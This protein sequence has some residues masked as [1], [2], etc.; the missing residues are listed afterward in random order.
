MATL[1]SKGSRP[2]P[3]Q[4][5][6]STP[7][8]DNTPAPRPATVPKATVAK[9]QAKSKTKQRRKRYQVYVPPDH[10]LSK[11]LEADTRKPGDVVVR[12]LAN[13]TPIIE[14]GRIPRHEPCGPRSKMNR[15]NIFV[16]VPEVERLEQLA[17]R[18][19]WTVTT[20]IRVLLE[21]ELLGYQGEANRR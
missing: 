7:T 9:P 1:R 4:E 2:T 8:P 15:Y 14:S 16:T 19:Q 20:L 6:A 11:A 12:A 5:K 17:D 13:H 18:R 10:E 21:V 3:P